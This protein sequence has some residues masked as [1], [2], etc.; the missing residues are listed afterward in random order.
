MLVKFIITENSLYPK[1]THIGMNWTNIFLPSVGDLIS[2]KDF[3]SEP[4]NDYLINNIFLVNSRT[5][6]KLGED[7]L[8]EIK[9][10][11]V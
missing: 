7:D 6:R 4:L 8:I 2:L 9:L 5:F 10:N 1:E 11:Y 3:I